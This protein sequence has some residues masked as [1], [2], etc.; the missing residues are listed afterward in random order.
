[1]C[2]KFLT[3]FNVALGP[4]AEKRSMKGLEKKFLGPI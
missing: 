2:R 1:M 3:R 4:S